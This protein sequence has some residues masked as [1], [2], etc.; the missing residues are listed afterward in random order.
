VYKGCPEKKTLCFPEK[1]PSRTTPLDPGIS[2]R[3][4]SAYTRAMG[5]RFCFVNTWR[6]SGSCVFVLY[7]ENKKNGAFQKKKPGFF[8]WT[9][10]K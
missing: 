6:I 5:F 8:F 9:P 1:K 4:K 3:E 2:S 7:P 10:D